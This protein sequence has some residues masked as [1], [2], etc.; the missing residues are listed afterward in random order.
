MVLNGY[1][2]FAYKNLRKVNL[3]GNRHISKEE[4]ERIPTEL[5]L[6]NELSLNR[7]RLN[8]AIV[9]SDSFPY[10]R[11]LHM[12]D[13]GLRS[14]AVR[15]DHLVEI[16]LNH[17]YSSPKLV[18]EKSSFDVPNL[19]MIHLMG[20]K[21][22]NFK[23]LN[24]LPKNTAKIFSVSLNKETDLNALIFQLKQVG[25][26]QVQLIGKTNGF[27][28]ESLEFMQAFPNQVISEA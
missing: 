16:N 10:L 7:C 24:C 8:S 15:G 28:K 11:S 13:T 26:I 9:F 2:L 21:Y 18:L 1:P 22:K 25:N 5:P 19:K 14:L 20:V 3:S 6:L 12:Q 4:V 23:Q 17:V 27:L